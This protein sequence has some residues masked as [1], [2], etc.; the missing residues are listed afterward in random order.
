MRPKGAPDEPRLE[1]V[2]N[3]YPDLLAARPLDRV[4]S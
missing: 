3:S 4:L 1:A 2:T